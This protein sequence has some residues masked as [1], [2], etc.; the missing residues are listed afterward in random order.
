[1]LPPIN[2][3]KILMDHTTKLKVVKVA[4]KIDTVWLAM[5]DQEKADYKLWWREMSKQHGMVF[6][7]LWR[8]HTNRAAIARMKDA[9]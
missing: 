4:R 7:E 5:I 9:T 3:E 1:M 8:V 2:E 6:R